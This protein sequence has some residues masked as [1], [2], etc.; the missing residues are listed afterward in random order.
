MQQNLKELTVWFQLTFTCLLILASGLVMAGEKNDAD[1]EKKS[2]VFIEEEK[3]GPIPEIAVYDRTFPIWGKE[4]VALGHEI[5]KP[6]GLSIIYMDLSQPLEVEKID[7]SGLPLGNPDGLGI[8]TGV[9]Q[10]RG[11]NITLR[12]D[13]WLL[14]F[15]NVYAVV[16]KTEGASNVIINNAEYDGKCDGDWECLAGQAIINGL[17]SP[18]AGV[19]VSMKYD[20]D[21]YGLGTTIAGGVGSWF[22]MSDMNFTYTNLNILDGKISTFVMSPRAG[23][24]FKLGDVESRIWLGAMYQDV[25]Q[26][27]SGNIGGILPSLQDLLPNGKFHVNQRL[28]ERWNGTLG[29]MFEIDRSFEILFEF[30]FGTRT[31]AMGS[32]GYRF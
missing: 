19:P 7:F 9:A 4:A 18:L 30:G 11:K 15:L 27:F 24:R 26:N 14:P 25:Q 32:L 20:G 22:I 29:A 31:S 3:E 2:V 8:D 6:F 12:A 1:A 17:L 21:T 16:G 23:Y 13:M 10:Q 28:M 5:P